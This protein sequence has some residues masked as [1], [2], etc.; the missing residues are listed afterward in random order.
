MLILAISV[1]TVLFITLIKETRKDL[2]N[3]A[4]TIE[5]GL[6]LAFVIGMTIFVIVFDYK[7][8]KAD[9]YTTDD[10]TFVYSTESETKRVKFIDACGREQDLEFFGTSKSFGGNS[11]FEIKD[12]NLLTYTILANKKK[13]CIVTYVCITKELAD[14]VEYPYEKTLEASTA[15]KGD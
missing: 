2:E 13:T 4:G 12:E 5:V 7:S 6:A 8:S 14:E 9:V 3:I 11:T 1:F 15:A 10:F